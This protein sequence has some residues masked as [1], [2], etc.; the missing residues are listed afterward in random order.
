M[1]SA[2]PSPCITLSQSLSEPACACDMPIDQSLTLPR[3]FLLEGMGSARYFTRAP[4]P[5]RALMWSCRVA[6]YSAGIGLGR[7]RVLPPLLVRPSTRESLQVYIL[8]QVQRFSQTSVLLLL[9]SVSIALYAPGQSS[10]LLLI[11][12]FLCQDFSLL[13]LASAYFPQDIH[14]CITRAKQ[15]EPIFSSTVLRQ[16]RRP[17]WVNV[18][19]EQ[20]LSYMH[21]PPLLRASLRLV[22]KELATSLWEKARALAPTQRSP[23]TKR[24]PR[25]VPGT[26]FRPCRPGS[27][28][29]RVWWRLSS[30]AS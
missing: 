7:V 5:V 25:N 24:G 18:N 8:H 19:A 6:A 30:S 23:G 21:L 3:L 4:R 29:E 28:R 26:P 15:K 27:W 17:S 1:Y 14:L 22:Y 12:Q 13:R 11:L 20:H 9:P 10:I 16:P 2:V